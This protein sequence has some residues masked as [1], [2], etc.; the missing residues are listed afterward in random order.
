MGNAVELIMKRDVLTL[1]PQ[2][3]LRQMDEA[4]IERNVSG[5]PVV[6]GARLVGVATRADALRAQLEDK[7]GV[8]D[9]S[10]FKQTIK[11][12]AVAFVLAVDGAAVAAC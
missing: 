6:E 12:A 4:L 5:A 3:S 11:E 1:S 10:D 8:A 9:L 2:M 7:L